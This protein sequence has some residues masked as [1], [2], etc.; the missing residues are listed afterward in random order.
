M[1]VAAS[2]PSFV[3]ML[4]AYAQRR[5]K[6]KVG[7]QKRSE[8][9]V[10][11]QYE[12]FRAGRLARASQDCFRHQDFAH[13]MKHGC[14]RQ[15]PQLHIVEAEGATRSASKSSHAHAMTISHRTRLTKVPHQSLRAVQPVKLSD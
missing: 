7:G 11:V 3:V 4:R 12:A 1:R 5:R 14:L 8:A 2:V 15:L 13:I 9:G 6:I 10:H